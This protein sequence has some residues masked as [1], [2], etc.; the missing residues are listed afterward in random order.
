MSVCTHACTIKTR[1]T[2]TQTDL[3]QQQDSAAGGVTR[4]RWQISSRRV[5]EFRIG[6]SD[7]EQ[8]SGQHSSA[9]SSFLSPQQLSSL[10][11]L[12]FLQTEREGAPGCYSNLLYFGISS[13]LQVSL[14][15]RL[16]VHYCPILSLNQYSYIYVVMTKQQSG[17][18]ADCVKKFSFNPQCYFPQIHMVNNNGWV[19]IWSCLYQT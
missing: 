1:V 13:S 17:G 4:R 12:H 9:A 8:C 11:Q 6:P 3:V 14:S 5:E 2:V 19:W 16:S 18:A 15:V 10:L 7:M